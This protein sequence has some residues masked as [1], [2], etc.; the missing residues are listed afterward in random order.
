MSTIY[1]L[2]IGRGKKFLGDAHR[3]VDLIVGGWQISNTLTYGTGLPF[4]PSIAEC[5]QVTDAGPCRPN[6]TGNLATGTTRNSNGT[7]WFT[8]VA[9]LAYNLTPGDVGVDSCTLARPSSGPLSLPACGQIG[10]MGF[11]TYLGSACLLRRHVVAEDFQHHGTLQGAVPLR[12]V[13]PLQPSCPGHR[14]ATPAWIAA[15]MRDRSR[16]SRP[17]QPR[18]PLSA[19]GNCSS[20]SNS[21]SNKTNKTPQNPRGALTG[22]PFFMF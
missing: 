2:P 22:S 16:T 5:S 14:Q 17:I 11:N 8:P 1:D 15:A 10:N 21:F 9:P 6:V 12:C 13:Q 19:C 18:V 7:F 3:A 20:A 4:T